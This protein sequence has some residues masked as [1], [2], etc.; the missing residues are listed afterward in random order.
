MSR[1]ASL[2][3]KLLV[4]GVAMVVSAIVASVV[5]AAM[6]DRTP[7]ST[8]GVAPEYTLA[9]AADTPTGTDTPAIPGP[10]VA[11]NEQSSGDPSPLPTLA[12]QDLQAASAAL[13][14]A[15]PASYI[16]PS[17]F[18]RIHPITQ[19]DGG[20]FQGSNCTLAS[21]AMLARLASGIVTNG[22][23]L[24]TLQDDQS[25]G[26][27]INDL[28]TALWRGYG[29]HYPSGMLRADQLKSLLGSGYGAVIQGDYSKIPRQL[30]LQKNFTGGHAIYLDGYYPG[31]PGRGIPEAYYVIDPIGR[32]WSGY[33]G[34][35]WPASVVDAFAGSFGGGR[36]R[37]MWAFPPGGVAPE[38]TG[39]DVLPIPAD[40]G[41]GGSPTP[42]PGPTAS[43]ETPSASPSSSPG[44]I[45]P[46]EPGDITVVQPPVDPPVGHG[47]LGGI[48]L[49][50]LF[51]I[52][53]ITPKPAGCPTG[54]E[55]IFSVPDPPLLQLK[56]GP[57][58]NVLFVDSNRANVAIVGFTVDPPAPADVHFW[59][60]GAS[61]GVVHSATSMSSAVLFGKTVQL[62]RLDVKA[63]TTYQFQAIAGSGL[64][65]GQSAVGSFTTGAG[66]EQFDVTLSQA[67]SPVFKLEAGLSPYLHLGAGA[68][69]QPMIPLGSLGGASC[70]ESATFGGQPFCLDLGAAAPPPAKCNR[71]EV[72]YAL[73]GIDAESVA[74]R[75]F[76]AVEGVTPTGAITLDGVLEASGPS[77]SGTVSV[78]CLAS[79]LTYNIALDAIGDDHGILAVQTIAV[80]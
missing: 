32:P 8:A 78:G 74:V 56:L 26:T 80:P 24:R 52:C 68:Y 57:T 62:A 15:E 72:S 1:L 45:V 66:V 10:P 43:G 41:G 6:Q 64:F 25:G 5:V 13:V 22:S 46:V 54:L 61:P 34:D 65:A 70:V 2:L 31:N 35:W 23:I 36:V 60:V 67:P 19:F 69:A 14:G 16:N 44:P 3:P 39:P 20:P 55:A 9:G 49:H 7:V 76:P 71:V 27:G 53:L 29:V 75:A 50:A 42:T 17:G 12:P 11:F 28:A 59:E 37:A 51:D 79:G 38:V 73:S 21:G 30:R 48:D 4:F 47:A 40:T 58:V 77:P 18:P 33:E 63:S